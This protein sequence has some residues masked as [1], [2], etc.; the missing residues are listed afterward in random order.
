VLLKGEEQEERIIITKN[1]LDTKVIFFLILSLVLSMLFVTPTAYADGLDKVVAG[2]IE[3]LR[4]DGTNVYSFNEKEELTVKCDVTNN[5]LEKGINLYVASY[6]KNG[7]VTQMLDV[8]AESKKFGKN[9]SSILSDTFTVPENIDENYH[10]KAFVMDD[11]LV[12][13]ASS[14][15]DRSLEQADEYFTDTPSVY[16]YYAPGVIRPDEGTIEM[17][18]CPDRPATEFGNGYDMPF[19]ISSAVNEGKMKFGNT[20]PQNLDPHTPMPKYLN[21]FNSHLSQYFS[22]IHG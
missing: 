16:R 5:S 18:I 11:D 3:F 21:L 22:Y 2:E 6:T 7:E 17:T 4:S 14:R 15:I 10:I 12:P 8:T 19:K 20:R 13:Y 1:I 9:E